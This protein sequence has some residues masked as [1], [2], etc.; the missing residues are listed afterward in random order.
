MDA[1]TAGTT[2][3]LSCHRVAHDM[4]KVAARQFWQA[5]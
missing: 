3:C 2:S 5:R 1:L 4:S